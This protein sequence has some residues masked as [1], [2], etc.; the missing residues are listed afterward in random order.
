ML[1]LPQQ[2]SSGLVFFNLVLLFAVFLLQKRALRF[3]FNVSKSKR[4][5]SIIV[6]FVFAL[7]SFWGQDWFHYFEAYS[8]LYDGN[9][10][11]MEDVYVWIAQHLSV[12]YISFRFAV[13][14]TGLIFLLLTIERL[15][16]KK[17][18]VLLFFGSIWIIWFSYARVSLGLSLGFWG[19]AVLYNP[20]R[21][22]LFSMISAIAAISVTYFFHKSAFVLQIALILTILSFILKR[23]MFFVTVVISI[24]FI[25]IIIRNSITDLLMLDAEEFEGVIEQSIYYGQHYMGTG[26]SSIRFTSSGASVGTFLGAIPY[27]L[28]LLQ[29]VMLLFRSNHHT[30]SKVIQSFIRLYII[31]IPIATLF[32][33]N[34]GVNSGTMF[35]RFLRFA[36]FPSAVLLAYYWEY[37]YFPKL[38]RWTFFMAAL[39]T[40]YSVSYSLYLAY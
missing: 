35:V 33:L 6:M 27:Y 1:P 28:L 11:H 4:V 20:Y 22:K 40:L 21:N 19:L 3:P 2:P 23:R 12:D 26:Q 8:E 39:S 38:T 17:D 13:W 15:P 32:S 24:P 30:E 34:I 9:P 37:K 31:L 5:I 16:L 36:A 10:G 14:G 18:L 29:S 7:F 25:I